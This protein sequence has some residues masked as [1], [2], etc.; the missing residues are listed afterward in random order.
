MRNLWLLFTQTVTVCL[1]IWFTVSTLKPEWVTSTPP[2]PL[3][4]QAPAQEPAPA[5]LASY[6][7]AVQLA[8]PAVVNIYTRPTPQQA[9]RSPR[10]Q[11]AES[12]KQHDLPTSTPLGSGVI[13]HQD[14]YILT[15]NHVLAGAEHIEVAL[16]DGRTALAQITGTD[17]DSDLA[18]LHIALKDLP[19]MPLNAA[20]L[21]VGDIVLAIGNPFGVGQATTQ[22]IVSALGR[23]HLGVSLYE[24]YIQTDAAINP[25]NSGGALVDSLGRLVGLNTAMYSEGG[26]S[27]GIGFAIPASMALEI[28][29]ELINTGTV[30]RGWW[31][32]EPQDL[33]ADLMQ[34]FSLPAHTQGAI[35][36]AVL[37][38]SPA[39]QAGLQVGDIVLTIDEH[40]VTDALGLL[41][42]IASL[43]A[44]QTVQIKVWRQG[45]YKNI[46]LLVGQRPASS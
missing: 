32:I 7:K 12:S 5:L 23:T 11:A 37:P 20:N 39:T 4:L 45:Q 18:V 21:H 33:S 25:G 31:G 29:H 6:A 14:G 22:G 8:A 42:H 24:N 43:K 27:L 35:V 41:Q 30:S 28:M 38:D 46:K 36:A 10:T 26:G 17:P 3:I 16:A 1:A 15:N 13:V 19:L 44:G 34:A 40:A 9:G 2:P